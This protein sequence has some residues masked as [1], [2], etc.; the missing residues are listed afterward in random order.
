MRA[1]AAVWCALASHLA[2]LRGSPVHLPFALPA[3]DALW[4][5]SALLFLDAATLSVWSTP[6]LLF[7]SKR[8][9]PWQVA[10]AGGGASAVGSVFQL[11]VFRWMLAH[12][13]AWMRPFLPSRDWITA[14]LAKYPNA[15]FM[16]IAIA[17]A[18][19]VP[20]A[21]LKLAA[22]V[23]RYPLPR[24]FAAVVLG[25]LPYTFA[26]ASLGKHLSLPPWLLLAIV[27]VLAASV[28]VDRIRAAARGSAD[29]AA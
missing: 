26:L 13:R 4:K 1:R 3:I 22:A 5:L 23:A 17:R 6:L 8:F 18:T 16:A 15:S 12:E 7:A 29:A 24:Y 2:A 11:M 14:T 27:A 28:V 9:E 20:D 10:L 25:A 19:P 21:P